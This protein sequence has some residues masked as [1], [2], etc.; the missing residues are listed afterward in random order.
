MCWKGLQSTYVVSAKELLYE[1]GYEVGGRQR[2][3]RVRPLYY[4]EG[5]PRMLG[6]LFDVLSS[7]HRA[8][9]AVGSPVMPEGGAALASV[10][11]SFMNHLLNHS[12]QPS[13][14]TGATPPS[15][16]Y[17]LP[18]EHICYPQLRL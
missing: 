9:R 18:R 3:R 2:Y 10:A 4:S 5:R 16:A 6:S 1:S 13:K 11:R 12:V 7:R 17:W 14:L 8:C 15:A